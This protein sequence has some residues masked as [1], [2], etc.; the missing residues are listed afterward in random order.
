MNER[1]FVFRIVKY[2][3]KKSKISPQQEE[4][5][6]TIER[7]HCLTR[8]QFLPLLTSIPPSH[9]WA[10]WRLWSRLFHQI[11]WIPWLSGR[12]IDRSTL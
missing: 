8:H 7:S 9:F 1:R 3:R 11:K 12:S 2:I 6:L 5:Y 10:S 4:V